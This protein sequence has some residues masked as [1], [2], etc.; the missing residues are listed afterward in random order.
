MAASGDLMGSHHTGSL[1]AWFFRHVIPFVD[2][3]WADPAHT[4]LR[5]AAHFFNYAVLSWLWFRAFR[6]WEL[7][8]QRPAWKLSWA[9]LGFAAAAAT[10]VADE[11]AQAFVPTRTGSPLD[12]ALDLAGALFAQLLILRVWL[13]RQRTA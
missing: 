11:S 4:F 10:A 12:V 5:K 1:V 8:A 3:R 7:R 13:S 9:L 2:Y 6:Y